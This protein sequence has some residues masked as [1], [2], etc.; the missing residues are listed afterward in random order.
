MTAVD[1]AAAARRLTSDERA[2]WADEQRVFVSS[3]MEELVEERRAVAATVRE[4]G[5]KPV[6][7]EEFGGRDD[8]PTRAYVSEVASSTIYLGILGRTYGRLL[9]TRRS[10]TH[11]EYREAER[12]GL[13]IAVWVRHGEEHQGDQRELINEI[14][15]FH[16]TGSFGGPQD[17]ALG[18]RARLERIAAEECSPWT[19][20]GDVIFR[21]QSI[22]NDGRTILVDA[23]IHD[24]QAL[25]LIEAMRP[26]SWLAAPQTNLTFAGRTFAV[27]VKAVTTDTTLTNITG[28]QIT[29]HIEPGPDP[30]SVAISTGLKTY[31]ADDVT[32]VALR[33]VIFDEPA[34]A[35]LVSFGGEIRDPLADMPSEP[36]SEEILRPIL[37]LLLTESLVGSG[38]AARLTRLRLSAPVEGRRQLRIEWQGQGR[39]GTAGETRELDGMINLP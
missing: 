8:D 21:A 3:V 26:S 22:R 7:F 10:A 12:R 28:A 31:S 38:R 6:C 39:P 17:L 14:R 37:R 27:R 30:W 9:P 19:K 15:T 33:R 32:D 18:V 20:L 36:L 13:R 16:T 29:L 34:P 11:E 25:G 35:M 23:A 2:T 5:A 4:M 24:P 1:I